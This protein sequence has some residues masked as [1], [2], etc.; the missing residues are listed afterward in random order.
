M[1]LAIGSDHAGFSLKEAIKQYFERRDHFF[2]DVGT[3][4]PF[5]RV[6]YPDYAKKA[7]DLVLSGE[8]VYGILVC[9]TGV[10]MSIAAN[11]NKGILAALVYYPDIARLARAH[12]N[13]NVIA[14]GGRIMGEELAIW[15]I[16]TFLNTE[17]EG[18]RHQMRVDK[19]HK[20]V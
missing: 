2:Y 13:A 1:K 20:S 4:D 17:F 11:K 12:N 5:E 19:I 14:L 3:F 8:A 7:C 9:G 18:G 15:C 6:D 10:G 16:E